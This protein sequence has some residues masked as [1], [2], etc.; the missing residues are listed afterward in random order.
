MGTQETFAIIGAGPADAKAAEALR[1]EGSGGR[2]API[3]DEVDRPYERSRLSKDHLQGK[4]EKE[5]ICV[6]PEGWYAEQ[7]VDLRRSARATALDLV[8]APA[9][10]RYRSAGRARQ[11]RASR[12]GSTHSV[13]SLRGCPRRRERRPAGAG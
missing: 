3:G 2:I 12:D 1:D 9:K 7:D 6:H 8:P 10:P 5:K 4:S 11:G 13:S